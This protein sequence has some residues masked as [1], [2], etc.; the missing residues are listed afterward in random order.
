MREKKEQININKTAE[1]PTV[2]LKHFLYLCLQDKHANTIFFS[3][4]F[5]D[6]SKHHETVIYTALL[7]GAEAIYVYKLGFT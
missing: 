5:A 4:V 7:H 2:L 3:A 6:Y 1:K